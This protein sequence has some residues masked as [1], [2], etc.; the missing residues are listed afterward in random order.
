MT[1]NASRKG[2]TSK[3][4]SILKRAMIQIYRRTLLNAFSNW[5]RY[6]KGQQNA[7]SSQSLS[8]AN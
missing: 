6:S 8:T 7:A 1:A 3:L 5:A 4:D 2:L